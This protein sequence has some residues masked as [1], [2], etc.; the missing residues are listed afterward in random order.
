M[1]NNCVTT[2]PTAF[3]RLNLAQA[4]GALNDNMIKLLIVFYL[5]SQYGQERAAT[6]AAIGSAAFVLPFLLF[7]ALAGSLADRFPKRRIIVAVKS[8]EVGIALLAVA[9]LWLNSRPILYGVV[10]LLGSHSALFAPAK[11]GVVPELVEREQLSAANS[12]LEMASYMAIVLGTALAPLLLQLAGGRHGVALLTGLVVALTGLAIARTLPLTPAI[13][14]GQTLDWSPLVYWR[15]LHGLRHD[16][17]LLLAV[18]GAAYFLFVAAFCQLNLL[19]YGMRYLGLSEAQSGYLFVAAAVG[20]GAG[21]LLAG[22]L[23]GRTVE[24]GVVPLG[25]AGLTIAS[26]ALHAVPPQL[27]LVLAFVVLFGI[28]AGLFIVPLQAFI[29]LRSPAE[30]RGAVLAASS[31]LSWVGALLASGLLWLLSGPMG[32]SPGGAF[33]VLA[34]TTLLLSLLTLIVLPDFLLRFLALAAMR[35]FYRLD[36]VGEQQVPADGPALLV[37]NHVSWLDAL[38]LIAT[39]QRRIR[40][41][42]EREIYN[43]PLL[44][45]LCNLMQVIPV[46]TKDGKKGLLEFIAMARQALDDGYLVCIFAEGEITRN[47]MLN[48]FK[49]GFERIVRGSDTPIIPVYIGG[50]WGSILSYAHG[51]LLSRFPSLLPYRVTVLFG[52]ALKA[53]SSAHDVRRAVMELSCDW[54]AARK[55]RRKPLGELFAKTARENWR[56]IAM[57]DTGGRELTYGKALIGAVALARKLKPLTAGAEMVGVCLPPTVG[58]ALVNIALTLNGTVPVNLNY[59]AS[60]DGIRSAMAQCGISTVIT[61]LVFLEKLGTLPE[62][63]GPLYVEELLAGLTAA[64]KRRAFLLARFMPLRWFAHPPGFT[65]DRLATV[66]FSSGSTGE[67]KGV[68]L[69]H[70]NILSNLEALRMVFRAT[71]RDNICSALPFFHSLGFT[72]TLWLPLVSG[73]SAAYHTNPLDGET[74]ARVVREKSSTLLIATPTFLMAYLRRAKAEDFRS[75]RLV[76]TG[77]EKLKTKLADSFQERF[78]IRPMEGYGATEL[79]PVISLSLP[80]IEIDGVRQ[81]G[82]RE[83]SVGLPVPGVVVKIVD[84]ESGV[85]LPEGEAGLILV[86]GPNVMAGYLGKAEKT[87]EVVRDGWYVTGDIGR[88]DDMGFLHIT[89]RLSRFSKIAGEMVPHGAVE[90]ALHAGLGQTGVV[91]VTGV[92][93]EKRGEKLVVV[94]A[95]EAGDAEKLHRLMSETDLP[96]LWKPGRDCYVAVDALPILGTGKLDLRGVK[97]AALAR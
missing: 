59:T 36:I 84:A 11:Y 20:I 73:F 66:I 51:K 55:K 40:F 38:L 32:V 34:A 89:D 44:K 33:T 90:D 69:T 50:A 56:R 19:P 17:Y 39:Q 45:Q 80:D 71:R 6:I 30:H 77:A 53:G 18:I 78:G 52:E 41:V 58:G 43:T 21:S 82:S 93:D 1:T 65:A 86:K 8:L 49:G 62:F 79:S 95:R 83:G 61:S 74:I 16:G 85:N 14:S 75:L 96:N 2:L 24:F 47:G 29:Q 46:S 48:R 25:A 28:S 64:D 4:C 57:S 63:P 81:T 54:F 97:E 70:H 9:G 15:T 22:R 76:I 31:F 92:P 91:A 72:G 10:F 87:A 37:A 42:M 67:P 94:Y 27:P 13:A 26:F 60:A 7:S 5:V 35:F 3:K 23:S 12:L 88:L 68:M